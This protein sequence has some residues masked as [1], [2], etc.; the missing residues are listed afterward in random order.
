MSLE[1]RIEKALQK[2]LGQ[3]GA[4][5]IPKPRDDQDDAGHY[6]G[7]GDALVDHLRSGGVKN[8]VKPMFTKAF[9]ESML[10]NLG[11]KVLDVP[12]KPKAK[13]VTSHDRDGNWRR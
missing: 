6:P 1:R 9:R 11:C 13:T 4:E 8:T 3:V 12:E 5:Y 2:A 10:E 7:S